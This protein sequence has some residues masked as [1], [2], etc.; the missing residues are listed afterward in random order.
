MTSRSC[1]AGH[2]P[3]AVSLCRS[4]VQLLA[5]IGTMY[6]RSAWRTTLTGAAGALHRRTCAARGAGCTSHP[7]A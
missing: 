6:A 1:A 2:A 4:V 5:C 7:G 3:Q